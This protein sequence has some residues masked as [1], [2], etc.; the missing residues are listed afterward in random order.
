MFWSN[1]CVDSTLLIMEWSI[2]KL[3]SSRYIGI[4]TDCVMA[5]KMLFMSCFNLE[6]TWLTLLL[7]E[8]FIECIFWSLNLLILLEDSITCFGYCVYKRPCFGQFQ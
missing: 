8:L 1:V 2:V 3:R 5:F 7:P 4:L 6:F